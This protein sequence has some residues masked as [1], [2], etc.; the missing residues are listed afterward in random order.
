MDTNQI[1]AY[2]GF[3][4]SLLGAGAAIDARLKLR[5]ARKLEAK[6]QEL[7]K[8]AADALISGLATR[9]T[10]R[11]YGAGGDQVI[12]TEVINPREFLEALHAA[13]LPTPGCGCEVCD[14]RRMRRAAAAVK[15]DEK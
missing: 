8:A 13:D 2:A 14:D 15:R 10:D 1:L 6:A 4:A 7:A 12:G 11:L 3:G 9:L 5:K